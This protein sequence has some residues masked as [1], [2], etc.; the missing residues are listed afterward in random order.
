MTAGA[1]GH[2]P[3]T[4]ESAMKA[5]ECEVWIRGESW[6]WIRPIYSRSSSDHEIYPA[7][8]RF[9]GVPRRDVMVRARRAI[10]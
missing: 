3:T 1:A 10:S 8:A 5:Y 9:L 2:R 4:G 7:V 6:G